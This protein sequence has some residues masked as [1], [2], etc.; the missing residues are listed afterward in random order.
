[1][2]TIKVDFIEV[3]Y[4]FW[5]DAGA[6]N[7]G[8]VRGLYRLKNNSV[9]IPI[10]FKRPFFFLLEIFL[11]NSSFNSISKLCEITMASVLFFIASIN[12]LRVAGVTALY[13]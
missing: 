10:V 1:M 2:G 4:H 6:I 11:F 13:V 8:Q 12:S 7:N 3:E 9:P 5:K